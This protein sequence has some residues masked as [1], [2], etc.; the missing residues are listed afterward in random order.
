MHVRRA[1]PPTWQDRE[2]LVHATE[3]RLAYR[4]RARVH[5]RVS[6]GRAIV[7]MHGARTEEPIEV[8]AC[9]VLHPSIEGARAR[10]A[11]LFDGAHGRGEVQISLGKGSSAV[12]EVRWSGMLAAP[13]FGRLERGVEEG[14][15][16]GARVFAGAVSRSAVIGDPTPWTTAADG[17]P[18]RLSP[19]GFAQAS[20]AANATLGARIAAAIKEVPGAEDARILELYS[21]A[22]NLTVLLARASSRVVAVESNREA[23][24][25]ARENLAARELRARVVEAD[26]EEHP[27]PAGSSIVVLDPPRT[28]ARRVAER[29]AVSRVRHIAYVSCDPA[30]LGR[31]LSILAPMYAPRAVEAFEMF[32]QTSHVET[33]VLLE[34]RSPGPP[35]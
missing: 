4:T 35:P 7:G 21:G 3:D 15:W 23:C 29:L 22:G 27:I 25:A 12:L 33:L 30:T 28:G 6:G 18:L 34:R 11:D 13:C 31:D 14:R 10:L 24:E 17:A 19:G 16:Q 20:S 1:L 9:A 2:I 8:A 32:P 26:A 5:V